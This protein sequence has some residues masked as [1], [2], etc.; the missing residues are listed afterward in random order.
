M[1]AAIGSTALGFEF[2]A[3]RVIAMSRH[4][5]PVHVCAVV[6]LRINDQV[7]DRQISEAEICHNSGNLVVR[8][9]SS[10]FRWKQEINHLQTK[11]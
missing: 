6:R 1:D 9:V 3:Y 8:R 2:C 7:W 5:T 10:A 4:A 11:A